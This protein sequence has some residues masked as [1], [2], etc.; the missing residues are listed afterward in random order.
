MRNQ[1]PFS[2]HPVSSAFQSALLLCL[3]TWAVCSPHAVSADLRESILFQATFDRSAD[4]ALAQGDAKIYTGDTLERKTSKA[5]LHVG[6]AVQWQKEGG[7]R[8]GALRFERKTK[9]L[10]YFKGGKNVPYAK[11]GFNGTVSFWMKL[12]PKEDLPPDFVD[13][14]QI[15]DK[16]WNDAS[17]FVDFDKAEERDFRLGAFSDFK[18]WN[19]NNR[20]FDDIPPRE[21]P[22]VFVKDPPFSRKRWTHVAFTWTKFNNAEGQGEAILYLDAKPQGSVRAKQQFTWKPE[23]AVIMLGI[24]YVGWLDELVILDRACTRDEIKKL[25]LHN[26]ATK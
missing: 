15:T 8:G 4:A 25:S 13:P 3:L 18:F 9:E 23:N 24:N 5:G 11:S 2:S 19:P 14:L 12:S 10:I 17:F 20:K 26:W 1:L 22:M 21:R 6:D 16:K 7:V